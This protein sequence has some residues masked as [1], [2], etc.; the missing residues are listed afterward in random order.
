MP[1]DDNNASRQPLDAACGSR[2]GDDRALVDRLRQGDMAAFDALVERHQ[3]MVYRA[4]LRVAGEAELAEE[5]A[6]DVF[7]ALY[8][9]IGEFRGD[10]LLSTWLYRVATNRARNAVT[11]RIVRQTRRTASLDAPMG[12]HS[13]GAEGEGPGLLDGL[14]APGLDPA[15]QAEAGRRMKALRKA[16]RELGDAHRE[17]LELRFFEDMSYEEIAERLE[18]SLG[19][20]KSR[21][22][23]ARQD[24]SERLRLS[25]PDLFEEFLPEPAAHARRGGEHA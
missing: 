11:S 3:A 8:Q 13:S 16:V 1:R 5:V 24:L 9:N 7:V 21:L 2:G 4:A 18:L 14:R 10:S 12:D 6:Q 22:S 19:T 23:R 25:S 20:V 15:R 17:I